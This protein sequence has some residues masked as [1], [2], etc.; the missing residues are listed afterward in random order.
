ME[1][2]A[3]IISVASI[4]CIV[5]FT[6]PVEVPRESLEKILSVVDKIDDDLKTLKDE[7]AIYLVEQDFTTPSQYV[8]TEYQS[9]TPEIENGTSPS[10]RVDYICILK[11]YIK[12]RKGFACWTVK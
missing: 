8:T 12:W 3:A 11:L 4:L 6:A 1:A 7:L 9:V 10:K 5:K 2:L